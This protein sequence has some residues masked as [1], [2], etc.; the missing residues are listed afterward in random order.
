MVLRFRRV[1]RYSL[2]LALKVMVMASVVEENLALL[3][4]LNSL[5]HSHSVRQS[6]PVTPPPSQGIS[7]RYQGGLQRTASKLTQATKR[8]S[9]AVSPSTGNTN[10]SEEQSNTVLSSTVI[11]L[12]EVHAQIDSGND[13]Q[14]VPPLEIEIQD[15][16]EKSLWY[17]ILENPSLQM[18]RGLVLFA[19]A[20]YG[21]NFPIV[22]LLDDAIPLSISAALRF[23]LAASVVSTV[24]LSRESDDVDQG[25]VKERNLAFWSGME[26]GVWYC[27]GYIAQGASSFNIP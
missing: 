5:S 7:R 18:G 1:K 25:V 13:F 23:G 22:K 14:E 15:P 26:I 3:A 6:L 21:T 11:E 20:I 12:Q 10:S 9:S 4:P 16:V 27:I 24:V 2:C 8:S 17:S 19:S